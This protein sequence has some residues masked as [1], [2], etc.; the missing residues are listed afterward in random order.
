MR[1]AKHRMGA[2]AVWKASAE[3]GVGNRHRAWGIVRSDML[4]LRRRWPW[5]SP[6]TEIRYCE[7]LTPVVAWEAVMGKGVTVDYGST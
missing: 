3:A 4:D 7:I 5:M 1:A 6:E 2:L